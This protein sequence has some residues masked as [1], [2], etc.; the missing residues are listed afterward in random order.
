MIAFVFPCAIQRFA[1][2]CT[3]P[4]AVFLDGYIYAA[5]QVET[6]IGGRLPLTK[7]V[8]SFLF[9]CFNNRAVTF[10]F[11]N[12][13]VAFFPLLKFEI[14]GISEIIRVNFLFCYD[15]C[16]RFAVVICYDPCS[17]DCY[18]CECYEKDRNVFFLHNV[19]PLFTVIRQ[20]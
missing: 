7:E 6:L 10:L 9:N 19:K 12:N 15:F 18:K 1:C 14:I 13:A 3:F 8:R 4:C 5:V 16:F 17:K 20:I 11:E 2:D